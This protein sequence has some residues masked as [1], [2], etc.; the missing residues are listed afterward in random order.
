MKHPILGRGVATCVIYVQIQGASPEISQ[1]RMLSPTPHPR[2]HRNIESSTS[3]HESLDSP[4]VAPRRNLRPDR[5][6]KIC[7]T[8][9]VELILFPHPRP[10]SHRHEKLPTIPRSPPSPRISRLP[11]NR[12]LVN[13]ESPPTAAVL[14]MLKLSWNAADHAQALSQCRFLEGPRP[15]LLASGRRAAA[16]AVSCCSSPASKAPALAVV[17]DGLARVEPGSGGLADRLRL[18]SLTEDGLSYK[19]RFIVRCYEVGMNKTATVET[20]ANLLQVF[21]ARASNCI[22]FLLMGFGQDEILSLIGE[23]LRDFLAL[24]VLLK[25]VDVEYLSNLK[26]K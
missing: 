5:G 17:S 13:H 20:I 7:R 18:G 23:N 21:L 19:E 10:R 4:A 22:N 1:E 26:P 25:V 15:G 14:E 3:R 6:P 9:P 2:S 24:E 16:A 8:S 12:R 11:G